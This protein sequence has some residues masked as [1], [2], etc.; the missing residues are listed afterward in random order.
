MA[1][2]ISHL[3]SALVKLH[4]QCCFQILACPC[5]EETDRPEQA[6]K[7]IIKAIRVLEQVVHKH[8]LKKLN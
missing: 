1:E 6:Q 8:R 5:N 4:L 7:K 2:Q 3:Y